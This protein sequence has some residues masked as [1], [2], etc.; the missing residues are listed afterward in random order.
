MSASAR[1]SGRF[2]SGAPDITSSTAPSMIR[3]TRAGLPGLAGSKV[4]STSLAW[5][6][7]PMWLRKSTAPVV[8]LF[9]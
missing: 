4:S 9:E 2:S 3:V 1:P 7:A 6:I 8:T 5:N